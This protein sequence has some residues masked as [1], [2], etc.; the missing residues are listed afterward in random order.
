MAGK[1]T[2]KILLHASATVGTKVHRWIVA[3]FAADTFAG[4]YA[5]M[6]KA[7]HAAG[8]AEAVKRLDP[9]AATDADGRPLTPIKLS[10]QK[11]PY[12]PHT[13]AASGLDD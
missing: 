3:A 13:T 12:N 10:V 8:D 2:E 7:A 11:V 6:L 9:N 4:I 5:G 1:Q